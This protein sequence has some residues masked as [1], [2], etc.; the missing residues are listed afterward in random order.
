MGSI[1]QNLAF[2]PPDAIFKLTELYNADTDPRKVN[3][4]Q[5]TYKDKH[6][7]PFVLPCVRL[8][9][10][11]ILDG[12][13]EYLPILGLPD[14]RAGSARL[15]FGN[16]SP[17]INEN[18]VRPSTMSGRESFGGDSDRDPR[19]GLF[20]H[21]LG[22][23]Q[24]FRFCFVRCSHTEICIGCLLASSVW[25]RRTSSRRCLPSPHIRCLH[26]SFRD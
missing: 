3:L 7:K 22:S 4:G 11:R 5:G 13:H 10:Q 20:M 19:L 18:K 24:C 2:I 14:F 23:C 12:N 21:H 1:A 6:G 26:S 16:H 9:K 17:A 8:A 25:N 15:I